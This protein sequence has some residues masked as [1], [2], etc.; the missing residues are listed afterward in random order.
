M[1]VLL[2]IH[3]LDQRVSVSVKEAKQDYPVFL[4]TLEF[5]VLL[6]ILDRLAHQEDQVKKDTVVIMDQL[7]RKAFEDLTVHKDFQ[8]FLVRTGS[9]EVREYSD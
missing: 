1:V 3:F 7:G 6:V 5:V 4:V 9:L 8:A 2:V